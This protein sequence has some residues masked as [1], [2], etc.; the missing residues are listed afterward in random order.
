MAVKHKE[1]LAAKHIFPFVFVFCAIVLGGPLYLIHRSAKGEEARLWLSAKTHHPVRIPWLETELP[2]AGSD[3]AVDLQELPATAAQASAGP[4]QNS[5]PAATVSHTIP[6]N[7]PMESDAK[8][9]PLGSMEW[10]NPP[11]NADLRAGDTIDVLGPGITV[12]DITVKA[13]L[14]SPSGAIWLLQ[15]E[16][17]KAAQLKQLIAHHRKGLKVKILNDE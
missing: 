8:D 3:G 16:E 4:A 11:K 9:D 6:R 17:S 7:P 5:E 12:T 10:S 2:G 13:T 15:L 14:D 1:I